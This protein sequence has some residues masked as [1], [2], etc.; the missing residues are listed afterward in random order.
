MEEREDET[1]SR[2]DTFSAPFGV[3]IRD[4]KGC[5]TVENKFRESG[6]EKAK[7][8]EGLHSSFVRQEIV[9][10]H[11]SSCMG[12]AD[13]ETLESAFSWELSE[14]FNFQGC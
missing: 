10:E 12:F 4:R 2:G 8:K 7:K 14:H 9:L 13:E 11:S 3:V 6:K 1:S 5:V